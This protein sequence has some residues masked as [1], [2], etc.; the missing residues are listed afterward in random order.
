MI[1]PTLEE[2]IISKCIQECTDRVNCLRKSNS[3]S[4]KINL[5]IDIQNNKIVYLKKKHKLL[6][7]YHYL[8]QLINQWGNIQEEQLSDVNRILR[9]FDCLELEDLCVSFDAFPIYSTFKYTSQEKIGPT[10][11]SKSSF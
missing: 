6:L 8:K 10:R 4:K 5:K 7:K 1:D 3:K 2:H 9:T 11:Y